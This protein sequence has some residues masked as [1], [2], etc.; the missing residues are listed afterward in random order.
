MKVTYTTTQELPLFLGAKN[1]ANSGLIIAANITSGSLAVQ[2]KV[3]SNWVT[4][5]TFTE[6]FVRSMDCAGFQIKCVVTGTVEYSVG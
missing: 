6:S 2:Y 4:A 1:R 3:G 5:E